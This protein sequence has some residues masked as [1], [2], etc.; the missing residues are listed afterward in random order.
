M[1]GDVIMSNYES[2]EKEILEALGNMKL[3]LPPSRDPSE[4]IAEALKN[5]HIEYPLSRAP[6]S[7]VADYHTSLSKTPLRV[8]APGSLRKGTVEDVIN[9][10][11]SGRVAEQADEDG[12]DVIEELRSYMDG[13]K[14]QKAGEY[15]VLYFVVS[16][17]DKDGVWAS[18]QDAKY[19]PASD[20]S[21]KVAPYIMDDVLQMQ[22]SETPAIGRD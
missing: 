4:K 15:T 19:A 11:L 17:Q 18:K 1:L 13:Y 16:M 22:F 7:I 3:E 9:F 6:F 8:M 2:K 20:L 12:L 21:E 14:K 10:L 5:K